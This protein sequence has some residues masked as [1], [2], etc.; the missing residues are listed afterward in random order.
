[1]LTSFAVQIAVVRGILLKNSERFLR[2]SHR[3]IADNITY[4]L[5]EVES[6][7]YSLC[8]S[9]PVQ[10]YLKERDPVKRI[11]LFRNVDTMFASINLVQHDV[12]GFTLYDREGAFLTANG[13]SHQ[14]I[15]Q[16]DSIPVDGGIQY[17]STYPPNQY[18]GIVLPSYAITS[19]IQALNAQ[20][21]AE[22]IG[23]AVLAMDLTYIRRQLEAA[24][25]N[26]NNIVFIADSGRLIASNTAVPPEGYAAWRDNREDFISGGGLVVMETALGRTGWRLVSL[27]EKDIVLEE[28]RF[29]QLITV[30]TAAVVAL[31]VFLFIL[32]LTRR[33]LAPISRIGKYMRG[34][35][36]NVR[37][38]ASGTVNKFELTGDERY[39]EFWL[40]SDAM[41]RMIESLEE[42]SALLL[43]KEKQYF[44]EVLERQRMEILAYRSQIKP[45]FLYNTLACVRGLAISRNAPEIAE[46]SQ[47]LSKML[48]YAVTGAD[49]VA[50][51]DELQHVR[52][53]AKIIG[54]RFLN[55][56]TISFEVDGALLQC[57]VPRLTLQPVVENAVFHGLEKRLGPGVITVSA[58]TAWGLL[59]VT[60]ADNGAGI[61]PVAL[62]RL[63]ARLSGGACGED[64]GGIG[65]LNI[66]NRLRLTYGTDI[67]IASEL[68][69]G[70]R[71]TVT[72]PEM[73]E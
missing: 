14:V 40:M 9:P 52:E 13:F 47:S 22:T 59:R 66:A 72:V 50:L 4:Y 1:M 53:Y 33:F 51:A 23:A 11:E 21:R 31:L 65:L 10:Q 30:V 58:S 29:V 70:T 3:Q 35:S 38:G 24:D 18:I 6:S 32:T 15:T 57:R 62:E 73:G 20:N 63:R 37:P 68:G 44:A 69:C 7:I 41:N 8:Y 54:Y 27:F 2:A 56:I 45:H 39:E 26:T 64:N 67:D 25:A 28:M 36:E 42:K 5:S 60:V 17:S 12:L 46:I 61:D 43:A 34:V 48:H 16:L 71:V 19:P 49:I 55:K